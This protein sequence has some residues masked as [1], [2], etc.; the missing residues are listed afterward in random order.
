M[1]E[2]NNYKTS[3]QRR[4]YQK[5][6]YKQRMEKQKK[7]EEQLK[8][9]GGDLLSKSLNDDSIDSEDEYKVYKKSENISHTND[10]IKPIKQMDEIKP[11]I[12]K[13]HIVNFKLKKA[14]EWI[15]KNVQK[16]A[17]AYIE[18]LSDQLGYNVET[19]VGL[20]ELL[21]ALEVYFNRQF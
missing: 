7:L 4:D 12:N 10:M 17:E 21:K 13:E 3:Q 14:I 6:Y 9:S 11:K 18:D 19:T 20:N 16:D 8:L 15:S 2:N 5:Q 1:S